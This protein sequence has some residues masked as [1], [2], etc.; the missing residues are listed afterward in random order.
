MSDSFIP[1]SDPLIGSTL[2]ARYRIDERLAR[3]GMATV[4][5]ARDLRLDRPVAV[6][7]LHAHLAEDETFR[8]K[9]TREALASARLS[10][11]NV[12]NVFDQGESEGI[13]YLVLEYVPGQTLRGLLQQQPRLSPGVTLE[14]LDQLLEG[15][16][17]AHRAGIVHRD[18]KPENILLTPDGRVKI[19][20]FGL[21]RAASRATSSNSS[22]M[23]TVAYLSPELL[24][25]GQAD[26]RSDIYAV[27][28]ILFEMLT[29]RQPFTGEHPEHIAYQH[30]TEN[31]PLPSEIVSTVPT[32]L[33]DLVVW[34]TRTE[35]EDR[36]ANARELLDETRRVEDELGLTAL[37]P[38]GVVDLI[39][40]TESG[41]RSENATQV[42]EPTA[43][44]LELPPTTVTEPEAAASSAVAVAE[45]LSTDLNT[46][47]SAVVRGT[48]RRRRRGWMLSFATL[49]ITALVAGAG[50]FLGDGP[51]AG[52]V[53]PGVAGTTPADAQTTLE[54]LGFTTAQV[55]ENSIDVPKGQ[56]IGT[57]PA[58]GTRVP[59]KSQVTIRI[60]AG[61]RLI[62]LPSV[63][64]AD[65]DLA[66]SA[67]TEAGFVVAA[68]RPE[69]FDSTVSAGS[70][71][72]VLGADSASIAVG[73]EV[74]EASTLTLVVSLGAIPSV[75]GSSLS[76]AT[77]T[78]ESA[79]LVVASSEAYSDDVPAGQVISA[80]PARTPTTKGDTIN[81]VVSKGPEMVTVPDVSGKTLTAAQAALQAAGLSGTSN[82]PQQNVPL[83][84][85]SYW[86]V[87]KVTSTN[88]AAGS[89]VQKGSS[90]TM[91]GVFNP[92]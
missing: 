71:I 25:R 22:L 81:V 76:E 18:L 41:D 82:Y 14:I 38:H 53:L 35:P 40:R 74:E 36:P 57:D 6:K 77:A 12:V 70:V 10:D 49:L 52:I 64:G 32:E 58:E 16:S 43:I 67:L 45:R 56:V 72:E 69:R 86:D 33:D 5:L 84:N 20:D 21:A 39:H 92:F 78:L 79:G 50:W 23:G 66:S 24:R 75:T 83:T 19:A 29:G 2:D 85:T 3:G 26:E 65:A 80:K 42:L 60:S 31:V 48:T 1:P 63:L 47:R 8:V 62:P 55:E 89:Q 30:A 28:I 11:P 87:V 4:Y 27:G 7:V 51:G 13:C 9:F 46:P 61:P 59:K 34:A 88:P 90:V 54:Q 37:S 17:A 68:E 73:T 91:N 44:A 15:L